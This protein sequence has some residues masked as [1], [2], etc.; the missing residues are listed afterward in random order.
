MGEIDAEVDVDAL[1]GF[2]QNAWEGS[3]IR[4]EIDR[5]IKPLHDF[6]T[7]TIH[8]LPLLGRAHPQRTAQTQPS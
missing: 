8:N 1:A 4:M 2:I 5:D 3:M 7:F 6:M